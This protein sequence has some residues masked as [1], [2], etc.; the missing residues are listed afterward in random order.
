MSDEPEGQGLTAL[1]PDPAALDELFSR[2]PINLTDDDVE[3]IVTEL[4]R[5]RD[6]WNLEEIAK[7]NKPKAASKAP[8]AKPASGPISLASLGL[9]IKAPSTDE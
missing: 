5:A 2:D 1:Q 8:K 4:R 6:K 3:T 9:T 7:A